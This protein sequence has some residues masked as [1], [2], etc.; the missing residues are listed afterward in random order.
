M[1][2]IATN[3]GAV[4]GRSG[5]GAGGAP[6]RQVLPWVAML[7]AFLSSYLTWR[8]IPDILFTVSDA[9]FIVSIGYLAS[10]RRL[11]SVPFGDLTP[12]WLASFGLLAAGLLIGSVAG[13]DPLRWVI[14][15]GQYA[16]AWIALPAALTGHGKT[17]LLSLGKAL[18]AG[19]VAMEAFGAVVYFGYQGSFWE[20]RN[21]FGVS[22]LTAQHRLGAFTADANW[23]GAAVSMAL[24]FV[25]FLMLKGEMR[26]S[27]AMVA[28]AILL[29]GL[30]LTASVTAFASAVAAFVV[31]FLTGRLRLSL[32]PLAIIAALLA[33][34]V[35]FDV[36]MPQTFE[37]RVFR[38]LESG[39]INE[40][41]TYIGRA[42]LMRDAWALAEN[43]ML[44]G[45]GADQYRVVSTLRAPVHDIYLLLWV[46]GGLLALF[47]WLGMMAVLAIRALAGYRQDRLATALAL[48]VLAVFF[49]FSVANPHM[50]AR[51]WALPPLLALALAAAYRAV[52]AASPVRRE[53]RQRGRVPAATA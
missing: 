48:S 23:N 52:P 35:Q 5:T 22:F 3:N 33:I 26:R 44:V 19:V 34:A 8:P 24:P 36:Q 50:Y 43:H 17:A 15:T 20:T 18:V 13:D 49:V 21:Q 47:G 11:S 1:N 10:R 7:A 32:K 51:F 46:E 12:L 9:L 42:E 27:L 30:A 25:Y 37:A 14:V 28:I 38:A 45:V 40:A 53:H 6:V 39:D 31:F 29:L 16:F 41:G 2:A 4:R